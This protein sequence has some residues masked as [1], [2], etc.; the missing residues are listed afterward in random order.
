MENVQKK[1]TV[2]CIVCGKD[3]YTNQK[4]LQKRIEKFGSEEEMRKNYKCRE[5]RKQK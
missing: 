3:K 2:R 4:V 1:N 5:C